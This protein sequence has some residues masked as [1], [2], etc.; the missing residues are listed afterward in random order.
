[1]GLLKN[2]PNSIVLIL[3]YWHQAFTGAHWIISL[4]IN[5]P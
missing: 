4:P 5:L 3:D 2:A 1:M